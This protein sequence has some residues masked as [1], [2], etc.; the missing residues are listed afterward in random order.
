MTI[1]TRLDEIERRL[2]P[3]GEDIRREIDAFAEALK[4]PET[5]AALLAEA[6]R[7]AGY[8]DER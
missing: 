3:P 5:R 6:E 7:Q 1:N 8:D 4:N 2:N